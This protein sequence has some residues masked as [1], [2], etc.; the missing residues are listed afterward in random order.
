MAL[1]QPVYRLTTYA[2]KDVTNSDPSTN[3][4]TPLTPAPNAPHAQAFRLATVQGL[5]GYAPYLNAPTGRS[6]KY[7]PLTARFDTGELQF[8]IQDQRING[9]SNVQRWVTAFIGNTNGKNLLIGRRCVVEE[10]LGDGL[11]FQPFY[12]GRISNVQLDDPANFRINVREPNDDLKLTVFQRLPSRAAHGLVTSQFIPLGLSANYGPFQSNG[13][14]GGTIQQISNGR[15]A[16]YLDSK[17]VKNPLN[18]VPNVMFNN[19]Y[20]G[21]SATNTSPVQSSVGSYVPGLLDL[22]RLELSIGNGAGQTFQFRITDLLPVTDSI[23]SKTLRIG[24]IV[25]TALSATNDA[26]YAPTTRFAPGTNVKLRILPGILNVSSDNPVMID[27]V[28]PAQILQDAVKGMYGIVDV[29]GTLVSGMCYDAQAFA[30]LITDASY[31][32][33]R[34]RITQSMML[35]DF[36]EKY[37]SPSGIGYRIE[38][39]YVNGMIQP[40]FVPFDARLPQAFTGLPSVTETDFADVKSFQWVAGKPLAGIEITTY[41][42]NTNQPGTD[43]TPSLITEQSATTTYLF[44]D[45]IDTAGQTQKI[46][47]LGIR[48]PY[49]SL[50]GSVTVTGSAPV[51]AALVTMA[52]SGI[53]DTA[54]NAIYSYYA[55]RFAR[56]ARVPP[57]PRFDV[58]R[59]PAA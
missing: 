28:H 16:V 47:A 33:P 37:I 8:R 25:F 42:E 17:S 40:V 39:Q 12:V 31:V 14:L 10:D 13:T 46:D 2:P 59:S 26:F 38:A 53:G 6:G 21:T 7:D 29:T 36:I 43:V 34:F 3:E 45:N 52:G 24:V 51:N 58:P 57:R 48:Y 30:T 55:T 11:G 1:F 23:A 15:Y 20:A 18:I 54:M 56:M 41:A 22:F 49:T 5:A 44:A 4:N 32:T 27:G 50:S 9:T 19:L 35:S